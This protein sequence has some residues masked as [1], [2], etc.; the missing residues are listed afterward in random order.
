MWPLCPCLQ[1]WGREGGAE[2][3]R[4]PGPPMNAYKQ[5]MSHHPAVTDPQLPKWQPLVELIFFFYH[6]FT[7]PPLC[8]WW[9]F[10]INVLWEFVAFSGPFPH[11]SHL[12]CT[13][14][15]LPTSCTQVSSTDLM[16]PTEFLQRV[17]MYTKAVR[18]RPYSQR[19]VLLDV[20]SATHTDS[21]RIPAQQMTVDVLTAP[22]RSRSKA[23][24]LD[25]RLPQTV[26][27]QSKFCWQVT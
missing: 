27:G 12:G 11:P 4:S 3:V 16:A 13:A 21:H 14:L 8:V 17:N 10:S 22:G 7:N 5:E 20:T 15:T 1:H 26:Q 23:V 19:K 9:N 18:K 24:L 6:Y 25:I 2:R